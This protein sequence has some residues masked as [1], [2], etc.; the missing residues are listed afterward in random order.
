MVQTGEHT[1][2]TKWTDRR[3]LQNIFSPC[4]TVDNNRLLNDIPISDQTTSRK[5]LVSDVRYTFHYGIMI[6]VAIGLILG[7]LIGSLLLLCMMAHRKR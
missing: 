5:P 6:A 3:M 1:Q 7:V 4:F 2:I